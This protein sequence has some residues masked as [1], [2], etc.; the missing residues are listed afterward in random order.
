MRIRRHFRG[1]IESHP[2][3]WAIAF[4]AF[5]VFP[6][7]FAWA[8][9]LRDPGSSWHAFWT[10]FG[11]LFPLDWRVLPV[12]GPMDLLWVSIPT[13][14]LG[15]AY[16]VY[17]NRMRDGRRSPGGELDSAEPGK[18]E[19]QWRDLSCEQLE[20]C[21]V[22]VCNAMASRPPDNPMP[23]ET[24]A[25]KVLRK[26]ILEGPDRDFEVVEMVESDV[27][28]PRGDGSLHTAR[29][30]QGILIR[31]WIDKE[32]ERRGCVKPSSRS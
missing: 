25:Y 14:L 8:D 24:A 11:G 28:I 4:L 7:I 21:R 30:S 5:T 31:D 22:E 10:W 18:A 19:Q 29:Q 3:G 2:V 20:A 26:H 32:L 13:G 6:G 23:R 1:S 16:V 27:S 17:V 12:V 15:I 9:Q